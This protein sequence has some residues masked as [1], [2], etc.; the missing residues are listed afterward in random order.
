M[1]DLKLLRDD[2]D[3]VRTSQR[4]RGEDPSL[5]DTLLSADE[6]RRG[7]IVEADTLRS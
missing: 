5:V 2:P 1:I 3:L 6:T 4:K 7:A